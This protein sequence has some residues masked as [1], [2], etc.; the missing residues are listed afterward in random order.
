M[1]DRSGGR[2]GHCHQR[3]QARSNP[4]I[5]PAQ[6]FARRKQLAGLSVPVSWPREDL[7]EFRPRS[8]HPPGSQCGIASLLGQRRHSQRARISCSL[9]ILRNERPLTQRFW[10]LA[11]P[12]QTSGKGNRPCLTCPVL[13]GWP[14]VVAHP[15]LP[16]TR[17]CAINAYGSS[18]H[19]F[20]ARRYTEWITTARGNGYRSRS[21]LKRGHG[22]VPSRRRRDSHLC[23]MRA[24]SRRNCP[25]AGALGVIP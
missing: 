25:N 3:P 19:G 17:T 20:A 23:Q 8:T 18:S 1:A 22:M 5:L 15:G 11:R 21:R 2:I 13:A 24:T 12:I 6:V 9:S 7:S 14:W 4:A 16:Q 10:R